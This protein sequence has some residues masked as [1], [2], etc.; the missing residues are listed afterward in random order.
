MKIADL[1][2]LDRLLALCQKRGVT[3]ITVDGVNLTLAPKVDKRVPTVR[4]VDTTVFPEASLTVPQYNGGTTED[5]TLPDKVDSDEL[6]EEQLL[7]YSV[8]DDQQVLN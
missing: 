6:T 5:T 2:Q 7:M 1:K 3:S 4:S 8:A